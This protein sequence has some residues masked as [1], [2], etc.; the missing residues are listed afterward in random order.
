MVPVL[1]LLRF[2]ADHVL[3]AQIVAVG[4]FEIVKI[5]ENRAYIRKDVRT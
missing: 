1:A 2:A 3:L 5:C 4:L